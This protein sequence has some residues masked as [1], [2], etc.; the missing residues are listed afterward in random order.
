MPSSNLMAGQKIISP[1]PRAKILCFY[2]QRVH[3]SI[4]EAKSTKFGAKRA[5]LQAF[6]G[7]IWPAGSMLCMPA[8][9]SQGFA[10]QSPLQYIKSIYGVKDSKK[11]G[12]SCSLKTSA[13]VLCC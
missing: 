4:K 12:I 3:L 6:A 7:H 13:T 5:K 10:K 11:V 8:L 9:N 2:I 1:Y